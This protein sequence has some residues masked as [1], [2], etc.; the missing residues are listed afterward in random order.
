MAVSQIT[1]EKEIRA[2]TLDEIGHVS[3]GESMTCVWWRVNDMCLV[4]SQ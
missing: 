3:G 2:L 1:E 4:A